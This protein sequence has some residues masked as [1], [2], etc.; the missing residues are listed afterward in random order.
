[1]LHFLQEHFL[2]PQQ[3]LGLSEEI[4]FRRLGFAAL[5]DIANLKGRAEP[6]ILL[7]IS[8]VIVAPI[9]IGTSAVERQRS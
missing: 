6:T 9:S 1:M 8:I 2:L 7:A 5:E 3:F 4:R